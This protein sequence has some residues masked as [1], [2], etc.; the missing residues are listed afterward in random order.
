MERTRIFEMLTRLGFAAR[1]L[2]Y[3]VVGLLVLGAGRAEDPGGVLEYL[4]TGIGK[5]LLIAMAAGFA[6]YGLWRAADA[7][8][9]I[10]C[11]G[12]EKEGL[13]RLGA[14]VSAAVHLYL[15][16][17]ALDTVEGAAQHSA[18]SAGEQAQSVLQ[19]P[20]GQLLLLAV[21]IGLA[22]AGLYQL[23]IAARCSFLKKLDERARE[24]WIKWLGRAGYAARGLVF[25]LVGY[26]ISRA[27]LTEN[28]SQAGGMEQVLEWLSNPMDMIIAGGLLLFGIYGLIE[29]WYRRLHVPDPVA[30]GRRMADH[31]TG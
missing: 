15:A 24:T 17:K 7:I 20:G 22:G 23:S 25:M 14:G 12:D 27:A 4:A 2:L 8:F 26:F 3:I 16:N 13:K 1:G 5:W 28:P 31:L 11:R 19:L 30:A 21:A 9:A 6:A 10:E 29:A 18:N